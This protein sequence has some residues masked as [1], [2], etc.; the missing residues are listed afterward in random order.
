[1][2][3]FSL[4]SCLF[5][6]DDLSLVFAF[7]FLLR[8]GF[9]SLELI[10]MTLERQQALSKVARKNRLNWSLF[11]YLGV[12]DTMAT[13]NKVLE[14][15]LLLAFPLAVDLVQNCSKVVI[16]NDV[17]LIQKSTTLWALMVAIHAFLDADLTE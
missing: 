11:V 2:L 17:L 9:L 16:F 14:E 6:L 15:S 7:Y 5:G 4:V 12:V 1:M 3:E 10:K 13:F 8:G